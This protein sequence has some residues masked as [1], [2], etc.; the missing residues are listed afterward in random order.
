[1]VVA[2]GSL[3]FQEIVRLEQERTRGCIHC[4]GQ[5]QKAIVLVKEAIFPWIH[6]IRLPLPWSV[7]HWHMVPTTADRETPLES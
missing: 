5:M 3:G 4:G 7:S 2:G 6:M 1:V